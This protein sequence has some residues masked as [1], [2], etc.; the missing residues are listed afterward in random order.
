[1]T[2][3]VPIGSSALDLAVEV[4]RAVGQ[5]T[6]IRILEHLGEPSGATPTELA[7][8]MGLTQQNV[9]KH[10][11]TLAQAEIVSRSRNGSQV[12][13][14]LA[15]RDVMGIVDTAVAVALRNLDQRS[16]RARG[17]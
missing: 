5:P 17:A 14:R 10:L 8:A 2:E 1:L 11:R 15:D 4:L 3:R 16:S 12:V 7:E 13:Y 6:R 9:S